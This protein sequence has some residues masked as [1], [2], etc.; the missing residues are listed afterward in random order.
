MARKATETRDLRVFP[1]ADRLDEGAAAA[2]ADLARRVAQ[3]E[4]RF[5]LVLA[6]GGTPRPLYRRLAAAHRDEVP[7]PRVHVFWGDERYVPAD[8]PESN[9]RMARETLL[10][11]VPI[12]AKNVHPFPTGFSDPEEAAATY[13]R[14]LRAFFEGALPRFD[15]V[16]LGLGA[17]GHVA[18][19]FPGSRALE[20]RARLVV[21]VRGPKPPPLRLTLT[22]P[23]LNAAAR[24]HFIVTGGAKADA[25]ERAIAGPRDPLAF[26]AHAV[27]PSGGAVTWWADREAAARIQTSED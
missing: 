17:D 22:L 9:V 14:S 2:V 23:A 16:L 19:L 4:G 3:A 20:E 5:T 7:W 26:P 21:P 12:P 6:G 24:V 8:H 27:Q 11:H 10:D 15:L 1:D 13:E 25:L 18:S